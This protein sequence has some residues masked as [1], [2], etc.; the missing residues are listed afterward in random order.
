MPA[1][2]THDQTPAHL[3]AL[4]LRHFADLRDGSHGGAVTRQDKE[5]LFAAA[6]DLLD[7][8][9]FQTFPL[10]SAPKAAR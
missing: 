2:T 5:A 1:T 3:R 8:S 4:L 6:V 9:R 10:P 7:R